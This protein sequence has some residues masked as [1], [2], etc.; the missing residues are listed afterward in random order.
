MVGKYVGFRHTCLIPAAEWKLCSH[1]T[2]T[3]TKLTE[4]LK[5]PRGCNLVYLNRSLGHVSWC[6]VARL[7]KTGV[8]TA[9][10]KH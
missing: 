7:M 3:G 8:E 9:C 6:S 10:K 4:K 2:I 5:E 1:L